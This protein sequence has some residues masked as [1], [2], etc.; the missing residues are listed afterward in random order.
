MLY[1]VYEHIVKPVLLCIIIVFA[2][3]VAVVTVSNV[4]C[5]FVKLS[6]T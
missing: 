1:V 5:H 3:V 2:V 4:R 6:S